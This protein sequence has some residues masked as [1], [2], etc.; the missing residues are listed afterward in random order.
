MRV[1]LWVVLGAVLVA[2]G[3]PMLY[4]TPLAAYGIGAGVGFLI[5]GVSQ[6]IWDALTPNLS[7]DVELSAETGRG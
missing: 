6:I 1:P 4:A 3:V 7:D 5:V 2:L